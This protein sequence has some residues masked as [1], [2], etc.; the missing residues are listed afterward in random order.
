MPAENNTGQSEKCNN[1]S[2]LLA[3]G[4]LVLN[5]DETL[6]VETTAI[7][8]KHSKTNAASLGPFCE[9]S[10]NRTTEI[11]TH[12]FIFKLLQSTGLPSDACKHMAKA[13]YRKSSNKKMGCT[14]KFC[15]TFANAKK[16]SETDLS[17]Q[18][19]IEFMQNVL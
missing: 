17:T 5:N 15:I 9:T 16:Y 6:Q 13:A 11:I 4:S 8:K 7:A 12:E 18:H 19:I 3:N 1:D 2:T 14:I 10:F